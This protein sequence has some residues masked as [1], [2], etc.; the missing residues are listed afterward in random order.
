M[1]VSNLDKNSPVKFIELIVNSYL[2]VQY[3]QMVQ[4]IKGLDEIDRQRRQRRC[5]PNASV[6]E[7]PKEWWRYAARC[8]IGRNTLAPKKT[9]ADVLQLARNS[10]TYVE[11]CAKLLSNPTSSL[12]PDIKKLKDQ[13]EIDRSFD[14][15]RVL[16]ELGKFDFL[17]KSPEDVKT[18]VKTR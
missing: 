10:V 2:K 15:L 5:R 12:P 3:D 11:A 4:C 13:M 8:Y 14:E 6:K 7:S 17:F 9:W 16:R 18:R 1:Y